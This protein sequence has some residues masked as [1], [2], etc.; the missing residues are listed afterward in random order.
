MEKNIIHIYRYQ[1]QRPRA[2]V[3]NSTGHTPGVHKY[4]IYI[5][6]SIQG[7]N[8]NTAVNIWLKY[9]KI[10][11]KYCKYK[12]IIMWFYSSICQLFMHMCV[13]MHMCIYLC[14]C[15]CMYIFMCLYVFIYAYVYVFMH[16]CICLCICV[17]MYVCIYADVY[18][19]VCI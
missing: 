6:D 3:Y 14:I 12:A 11:I 18:V 2:R 16:M 13:F 5:K 10:E 8:S 17:C 1:A 19:C 7:Y 4:R 15:V 9:Y